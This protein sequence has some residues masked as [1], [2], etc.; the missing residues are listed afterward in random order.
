MIVL[1][2]ASELCCGQIIMEVRVSYP[3][4]GGGEELCKGA[5]EN[6]VGRSSDRKGTGQ[7]KVTTTLIHHI[8]MHS[9]FFFF[10]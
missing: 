3:Y 8:T 7:A 1:G 6:Y 5:R 2:E 10:L 4:V 9:P